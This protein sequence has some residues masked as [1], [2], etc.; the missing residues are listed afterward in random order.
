MGDA[1]DH[2]EVTPKFCVISS[3]GREFGVVRMKALARN[4][5]WWPGIDQDIERTVRYCTACQYI[6]KD[7]GPAY[8]NPW[9]WPHTP[10]A[11]IY[12]DYEGLFESHMLLVVIDTYFKW[13][14]FFKMSSSTAT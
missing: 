9:S 14:E 6:Q 1:N 12:V 2:T 4:Y 13:L 5:M 3:S 7:P 8:L 10:W 11:C